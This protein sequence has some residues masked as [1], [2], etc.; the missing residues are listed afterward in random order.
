MNSDRK[1]LVLVVDDEESNRD[2]CQYALELS[3]YE[4]VV[5]PGTH[6]AVEVISTREVDFIICDVTMPHNGQRV[7][8]YLLTNFPQLR[9]RFLF[10][11]GNPQCKDEVSNLPAAA[12]CLMKP[13]SL[14]TLLETLHAALRA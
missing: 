12:P 11:T 9:G 6:E 2:F 7:Y 3:G 4:V 14:R 13:Y 10:V 8:Q 1:A 5:A